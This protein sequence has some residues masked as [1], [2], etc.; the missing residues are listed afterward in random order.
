MGSTFSDQERVKPPTS[1]AGTLSCALALAGVVLTAAPAL[2]ST[3]ATGPLARV[4]VTSPAGVED[5]A[6]AVVRAGGR[7]TDRL[8]LVG[9]VAAD[10]PQGAVLG[11]AYVVA[12]D[13]PL[14]LSGTVTKR[15]SEVLSTV[16]ATLKQGKPAAEGRGITIAVVD[17]GVA[18]V[19]DLKGRV[20]HVDVSGENRKDAVQDGYGHGTFV[21]GLVA[22]DGSSSDGR[23]AG[24]APGAD[25]LD[26]KVAADDGS[27]SLV[28]VLKGLQVAARHDADV[29]NLSLSSGSPLPYQLDPLTL[30]LDELWRRGTVVVVPAGNDGDGPGTIS[31][32]GV[33]PMLLTV[34]SVDEHGT[35][36]RSDDTIASSSGQGPAPQG[37]AKPDLAAAGAHLVS[38]RA[39]GSVIDTTYPGSRVED[40]YFR[41]SGTSFATAVAS[42]AAAVLLDRRKALTP[43]QV[44][45][46]LTGTAYDAAGLADPTLA[47]AGGMDLAAALAD[48]SSKAGLWAGITTDHGD[49]ALPPGDATD[50]QALLDALDAGDAATAARNW[51][52]LSP[53]A[54]NWSARNW[55]GLT[56]QGRAEAITAW[57]Q[58]WPV[59]AGELPWAARNWSARNWSARNWSAR[60]WSANSW[61]A[62]N[63]SEADWSARNWSARN[64]SARNWSEAEWSARNW[65]ARNWSGAEWSARNWSARNWSANSWSAEVWA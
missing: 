50:W 28:D 20:S 63:W 45:G 23:Y 32:P 4:I 15:G 65:S 31:S 57:D 36:D 9:G 55:S 61:S 18:D 16:R 12:A 37:V 34:G 56:E 25:I 14:K 38:L 52:R 53:A 44:K 10:L 49:D 46:V 13:R 47:G 35:A 11:A 40:D 17:T 39:P 8:D 5:A 29:V 2:A 54:R 48:V 7:V 27:T 30:A 51:S 43:N 19:A 1:L 58:N 64:W 24:V 21:A 22:G 41:G 26:V 62:R 42:G 59:V 33:D 6:S 60:N 3:T